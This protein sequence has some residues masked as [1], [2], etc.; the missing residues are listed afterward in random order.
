MLKPQEGKEWEYNGG[1]FQL[2]ESIFSLQLDRKGF[3][4]R[5]IPWDKG[6]T[7]MCSRAECRL[8][9]RLPLLSVSSVYDSVTEKFH[10]KFFYFHSL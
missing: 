7:K 1:Y 5:F 6:V 4:A 3:F 2:R 9:T 10:Y 8:V